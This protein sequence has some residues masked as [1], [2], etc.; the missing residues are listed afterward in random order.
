MFFSTVNAW[1]SPDSYAFGTAKSATRVGSTRRQRWNL[2]LAKN[3][4]NGANCLIRNY[5]LRLHRKSIEVYSTEKKGLMV[6]AHR[7]PFCRLR[8]TNYSVRK[9]AK[10]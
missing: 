10:N 9:R 7:Q 1:L 4:S 3:T 2:R 5:P 8:F 6:H